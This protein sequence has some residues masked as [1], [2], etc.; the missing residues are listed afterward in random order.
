MLDRLRTRIEKRIDALKRVKL[1][2]YEVA[3]AEMEV[4]RNLLLRARR[5]LEQGRP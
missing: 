2:G 1:A 3:I 4:E 5:Y